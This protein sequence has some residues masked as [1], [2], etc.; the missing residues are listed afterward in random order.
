MMKMLASDHH[1]SP[2]KCSGM[3]VCHR[4]LN[5]LLS[6]PEKE[7]RSAVNTLWNLVV[8]CFDHPVY[9]CSVA[10]CRVSQQS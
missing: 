9:W 7:Y 1:N 10:P 4:I 5:L 3:F 8:Y 2:H 6:V